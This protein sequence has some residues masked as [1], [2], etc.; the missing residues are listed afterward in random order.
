MS[1]FYIHVCLIERLE[2]TPPSFPLGPLGEPGISEVMDLGQ[3]R[4][5]QQVEFPVALRVTGVWVARQ[6]EEVFEGSHHLV[7]PLLLSSGLC[8]RR[9]LGECTP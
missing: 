6:V 7:A 1:G 4:G 5:E 8:W 3:C 2:K 9:R